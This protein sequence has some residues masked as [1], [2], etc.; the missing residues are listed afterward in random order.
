MWI[1]SAGCRSVRCLGSY[2]WPRTEAPHSSVLNCETK[3]RWPAQLTPSL[4]PASFSAAAVR[5]RPAGRGGST[6]PLV[7]ST[8]NQPCC[9][10]LTLCGPKSYFSFMAH[11]RLA[12]IMH[13]LRTTEEKMVMWLTQDHTWGTRSL[14]K[15]L[16]LYP[17]TSLRFT[18]GVTFSWKPLLTHTKCIHPFIH[19]SIHPPIRSSTRSRNIYR[20]NIYKYWPWGRHFVSGSTAGDSDKTQKKKRKEKSRGVYILLA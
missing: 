12:P 19:P 5:P 13:E 14:S 8:L 4:Y 7:F 11:H 18:S 3:S 15:R 9:P 2:H 20:A 16:F 1:N 10:W 17:K 6:V